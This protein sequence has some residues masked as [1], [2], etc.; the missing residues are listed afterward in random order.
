MTYHFDQEISRKGT[1]SVKWEFGPAGEKLVQWDQTDPTLGAERVLPMWVADMDFRCPQPVIDALVARA[2]HGIFGYAMPTETYRTAIVNWMARR[3]GWVVDPE[4]IVLTPGVVVALNLLVRTFVAPG[5]KVMIQ[6]PVYP[7]VVTAISNCGIEIAQNPLCYNDGQYT[8]DFGGL[9]A[10]V[11]DPAVTMAILCN[12]HNPVGRV[13][14]RSELER[15][16]QLCLENHVLVVADEIHGDLIYP[17]HSFTPFA[18]LGDAFAQNTVVCTA[19]SKTFNL[20]GLGTSN[21]IFPNTSHRTRF[22]RILET[23]GLFGANVFGLTALE[24]AYTHGEAWLAA[25]MGY[26]AENFRFLEDYLARRIPQI[27]AVRPEGTYLVWLDCT[28]LGLG[29]EALER[30]M[31]SDARLFLSEGYHF[32][33]EGEGFERINIACPRS[34]LAEA[35]QRLEVAVVDGVL[36]S[37]ND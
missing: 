24:A 9:E 28:R 33:V 20:A 16:G 6:P 27:T 19:P 3:Q 25:V 36:S 23:S 5:E 29:K 32:G 1:H 13:W 2:E 8:M 26:V 10:L 7:P 34:I 18:S 14:T 15:F 12:P 4:W 17:G 35:L 37:A 11:R 31:L 30:V 21:I 22:E